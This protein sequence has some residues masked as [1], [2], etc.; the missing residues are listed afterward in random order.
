[1]LDG[2]V[3]LHLALGAAAG[4]FTNNLFRWLHDEGACD[5]RLAAIDWAEYREL[6]AAGRSGYDELERARRAVARFLAGKTKHEVLEAS[7]ERKLLAAPIVTVA[8]LAESPQLEARSFWVEL[9]G[10]VLPGPFAHTS[11][12]AFAFRKPAPQLGEHNAEVFG[13]IM[14][15]RA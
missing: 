15:V 2:Y 13:A 10:H 6:L 9:G 4:R 3:V 8:D 1:M 7:L 14:G 11:A 12:D 5:E